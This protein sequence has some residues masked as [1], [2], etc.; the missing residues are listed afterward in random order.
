MLEEPPTRYTLS[1]PKHKLNIATGVARAMAYL[2]A[3]QPI[4]IHRDLKP[5]NILIDDGFNGKIADF[6]TSREMDMDKT[7][8]LPSFCTSLRRT[9]I[10]NYV[11]TRG[12]VV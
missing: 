5:E 7:M 6:G 2:H 11:E 9:T 3:Q 8:E 1:W 12:L 4:V 10:T